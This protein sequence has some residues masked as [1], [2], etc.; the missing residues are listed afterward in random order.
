MVCY[1]AYNTSTKCLE[2]MNQITVIVGGGGGGGYSCCLS[3]LIS[4]LDNAIETC[5]KESSVINI[6]GL[7]ALLHT[8][9]DSLPN[10]RTYSS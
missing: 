5:G 2:S 9:V 7:L 3:H 8:Y 6:Y 10:I 4:P 1:N